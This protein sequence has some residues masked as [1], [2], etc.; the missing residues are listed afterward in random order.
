MCS[1]ISVAVC[2]SVNSDSDVN[3]KLCLI[4]MYV[5]FH[6]FSYFRKPA[7]SLGEENRMGK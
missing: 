6:V 4:I 5:Y 7:E 3:L 2:S 1:N